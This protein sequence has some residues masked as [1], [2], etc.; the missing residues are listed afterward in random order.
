M[1]KIWDLKERIKCRDCEHLAVSLIINNNNTDLTT[2]CPKHEQLIHPD[3]AHF[4]DLFSKCE[5][6][7]YTEKVPMRVLESTVEDTG[8][9]GFRPGHESKEIQPEDVVGWMDDTGEIH[10][11][12]DEKTDEKRDG[13]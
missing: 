4:C 3:V 13:E 1:S 11:F 8:E 6:G 10:S 7:R 12:E 5:F 9:W 2:Y